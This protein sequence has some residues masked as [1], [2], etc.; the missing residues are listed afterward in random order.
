M[1]WYEPDVKGVEQ[2]KEKVQNPKILFY[3]SSSIRLWTTLEEDFKEYAPLNMGFGGSTLAACIV[4]FDRL[5]KDLHPDILLIYA[6]DNDLG[7][8]RHP[9]EVLIFFQQMI[10]KVRERFG[11]I[12]VMFVSVKPS[13]RRFNILEQIKF[14]NKIIAAEVEKMDSQVFF[15][16]VFDKMLDPKNHPNWSLFQSEGLHINEKGYAIWTSVIKEFM[17]EHNISLQ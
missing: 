7:D 13:I 12:P 11:M 15:I 16:N 8:G 1:F 2:R 6:G 5:M 3:G 9:E 4:Y 17:I 14:T 10:V